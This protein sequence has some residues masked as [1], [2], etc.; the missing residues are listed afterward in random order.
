MYFLNVNG[1][2]ENLFKVNTRLRTY[3]NNNYIPTLK[4]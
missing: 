1:I 4:R 2:S 3:T